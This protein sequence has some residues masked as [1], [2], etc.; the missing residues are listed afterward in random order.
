V[1]ILKWL[2]Q[3]AYLLLIIVLLAIYVN[4]EAI[5]PEEVTESLEAGALAGKVEELV[6]RLRSERETSAS[7]PA[8]TESVVQSADGVL[9]PLP[10]EDAAAPQQEYS[11]EPKL[12]DV[13]AAEEATLA[14]VQPVETGDGVTAEID[15]TDAA[16]AATIAVEGATAEVEETLPSY[17]LSGT[18]AAGAAPVVATAT[19]VGEATEDAPSGVTQPPGLSDAAPA[20]TEAAVAGGMVTPVADATLSAQSVD[21][22]QSPEAAD[23]VA[24]QNTAPEPLAGT[25]SAPSEPPLAVWRD[26]RAA[27]WQGELDT[28]V[29]RYRQL[30]TLQPDNFDAYGEMGNVLLAQSDA[31]AAMEA[32]ISAARLIRKAGHT[33]MAYRLASVVAAMDEEQGR[34]LFSEFSQR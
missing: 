25:V 24:A 15:T 10:T 14:I 3:P 7:S 16:D 23:D 29:A 20:A 34:A 1:R 17:P 5:F 2:F 32:Y 33:E 30:I 11:P 9:S 4:R 6:T 19:A 13:V 31:A 28:A 27:V 26:A 22:L 18:T 8:T 12:P 21:P